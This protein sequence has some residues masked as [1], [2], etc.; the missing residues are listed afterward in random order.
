MRLVKR[1]LKNLYTVYKKLIISLIIPKS[2]LDMIP[3]ICIPWLSLNLKARIIKN[4]A[5]SDTNLNYYKR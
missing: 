4:K 5:N 1:L 3:H 2:K